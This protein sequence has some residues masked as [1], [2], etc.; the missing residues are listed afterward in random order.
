M[1]SNGEVFFGE[2]LLVEAEVLDL[3]ELLLVDVL[4][5]FGL[6]FNVVEEDVDQV[7]EQDH[8][9]V[10]T[11]SSQEQIEA[12]TSQLAKVEG[13][14]HDAYILAGDDSVEVVE[15]FDRV[16]G[17]GDWLWRIDLSGVNE[18]PD[19]GVGGEGTV[20]DVED[21]ADVELLVGLD[22]KNPD[23]IQVLAG[24]GCCSFF[25]ELGNLLRSSNGGVD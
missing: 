21:V 2:L 20:H 10:F 3:V 8:A 25:Q 17:D 13:G 24:D 16:L 23:R 1:V 19:D 12:A 5:H 14:A 7:L 15:V 6:L 11:R 9:A 18:A 22:E 4:G